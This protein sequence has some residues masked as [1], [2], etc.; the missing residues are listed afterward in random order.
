MKK[1]NLMREMACEERPY[2]RCEQFGANNL[3]DCELLAVLLRTGTRGENALQLAEKILHPVFSQKGV[4]N[5]H[6]WTYEQL[7]QIKGIGK[8][9]AIQILCLSELSRRLAKATAQEGLNFSNP[10]SIARYYME[11]L[12]HANQEQMKL[13]L[14]NTKSRLIGETD[15]SKGTV[16]A[17]VISP[18]E[19]FVEALQKNAVSIVLLHNH[20]SGDPTPSKEDVLITRRIQ[21][22]GLL[23][24]VELLDH[25]V[26]G[27]NCYVSLREK[28]LIR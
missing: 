7:R 5:L 25:I 4:L 24:G 10:A 12:R 18:R 1:T 2:E 15:I 21:E 17:A 9:K 19:L 26:I 3:T 28:G 8:V 6:Q 23:I 16:N 27:D 20:P 13:L 11:D 14:L 22:A